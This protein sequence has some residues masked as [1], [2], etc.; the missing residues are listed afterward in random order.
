MTDKIT[1]HDGLRRRC[2]RLGHEVS[3]AYCRSPAAPLPCRRIVD[4]WR[5]TFDVKAFLEGH[6]TCKQIE[7]IA[8]PPADK[9]CS[10]IELI[11]RARQAQA[12]ADAADDT[13]D[14]VQR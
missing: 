6:F 13:A 2:P 3:F 9:M 1:R 12:S 4:C 14:Q 8:A 11:A 7:Q 10:L 5:E